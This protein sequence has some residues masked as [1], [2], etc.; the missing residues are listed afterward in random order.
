MERRIAAE[1]DAGP[2]GLLCRLT[3]KA[4][5][6]A[7]GAAEIRHRRRVSRPIL[8]RRLALST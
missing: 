8:Y 2:L 3:S 1:H 4:V 6:R 5:Y 7:L